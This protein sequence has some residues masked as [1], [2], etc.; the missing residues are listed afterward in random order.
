MLPPGSDRSLTCTTAS[1]HRQHVLV[2]ELG[3]IEGLARVDALFIDKTA[4]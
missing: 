2:Q 3:A 4:P 1:V